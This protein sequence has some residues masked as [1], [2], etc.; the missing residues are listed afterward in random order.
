MHRQI[1]IH[2]ETTQDCPARAHTHTHTHVHTHTH[3]HQTHTQSP[4]TFHWPVL[5]ECIVC[6]VRDNTFIILWS[7]VPVFQS[8]N[9]LSLYFN[10]NSSAGLI[11]TLLI[12][13]NK[14]GNSLMFCRTHRN[15]R[16]HIHTHSRN[17][18]GRQPTSCEYPQPPVWHGTLASIHIKALVR[19]AV[20]LHLSSYTVGV[21]AWIQM[22][23]CIMHRVLQCVLRT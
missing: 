16:A 20:Y 21:M 14:G 10:V 23:S 11:K 4:N 17:N 22:Q 15:T 3:T 8:E 2:R 18:M 12:K 6:L 7:I 9:S 13:Q 5:V 1:Y 19:G